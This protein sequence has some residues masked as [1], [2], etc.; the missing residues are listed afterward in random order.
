M[1]GL[2]IAMDIKGLKKEGHSIR[3]IAEITGHSR[4]TIRKVLRDEHP[5]K[6]QTPPKKSKLD[7]YKEYVKKRYEEVELSAVRIH[8]EIEKMGY[9]G[10]VTTIRRYLAKLKPEKV[11]LSKLTVRYETPPGKQAQADWGFCGKFLNGQG[12]KVSVHAFIMILGFS[13]MSFVCFTTSMKMKELIDCHQKAFEFFGGWPEEI[14]YDN[15]K[16]IRLNW[17]KK[18][19]QFLDFSRYYG[20]TAKTH[21]PYRP[22]TK[23]KVE[24]GVGYLKNN[25]L[26]GRVFDDLTDLNAQAVNWA[27]HTANVRVHGTTGVA[28]IELFPKETLTALNSIQP[29]RWSEPVN[30]QVNWESMVRF[31][32]SRYSVPPT[33]AGQTVEVEASGGRITIRQGDLIIAEHKQALKAGQSIVDKD[34]LAELWKLTSQQVSAPGGKEPRWHI[35]FDQTVDQAALCDFEEVT[36]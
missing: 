31:K 23:G 1:I 11:R 14:L 16:Q 22:R 7:R 30:R 20:F 35:R 12:K 6:F 34:H 8:E 15:M 25:F 32:G 27:E 13:R 9:S 17:L 18:N 2:E 29:Y 19:E 24:R 21:R 26:A 4:N 33:H 10:S 36:P 5:L 28:P 3:K